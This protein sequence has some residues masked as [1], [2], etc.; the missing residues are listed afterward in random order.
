MDVCNTNFLCGLFDLLISNLIQV[1]LYIAFCFVFY[2]L[3]AQSRSREV[4]RENFINGIMFYINIQAFNAIK[5]LE[6]YNEDEQELVRIAKTRL[7]KKIM[8]RV[9]C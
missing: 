7:A 8:P 6:K 4:C 2:Q 1:L 3:G 9:P 5:P